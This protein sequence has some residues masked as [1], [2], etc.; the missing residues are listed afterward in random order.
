VHD[1]D[2][3]QSWK[4]WESFV[5]SLT[6]KITEIDETIPE[7]PPKDLVRVCRKSILQADSAGISHLSRCEVLKRPDSIQS[8]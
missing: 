7:L 6:D 4:D 8:A 1:P 2:Y 5:E 3:R